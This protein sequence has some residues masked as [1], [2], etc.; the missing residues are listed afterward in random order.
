MHAHTNEKCR[1]CV[2]RE[3]RREQEGEEAR[4]RCETVEFGELRCY[5]F[6]TLAKQNLSRTCPP[7]DL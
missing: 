3:K 6:L 1:K 2:P 4:G 5:C 7:E